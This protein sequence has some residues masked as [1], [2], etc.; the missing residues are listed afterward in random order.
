LLP[1]N[2][3]IWRT[4]KVLRRQNSDPSFPYRMRYVRKLRQYDPA[5]YRFSQCSLP[6]LF[7][8]LVSS[9]DEIRPQ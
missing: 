6:L 8:S 2:K 7:V 5:N 1:Q 4:Y 9:L 3:N